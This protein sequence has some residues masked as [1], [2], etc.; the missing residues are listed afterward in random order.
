MPS[1]YLIDETGVVHGPDGRLDPWAWRWHPASRPHGA[2]AVSP[3]TVLAAL[4]AAGTMRRLPVGVIGPRE[5]TPAQEASA[6]IVGAGIAGM[7]L[8][9]VCGGRSGVMTAAAEGA[10]GAGGLTVGILPGS[11]WRE[12]NDHIAMP[13]A[14][15]IGEARNMVIAKACA[16]LVAVGGS[17]G[18]LSEIAYGLHF[19][20]P[21]I[22]LAD[23]PEVAGLER[24]RDAEDALDRL[25]GHLLASATS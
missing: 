19:A 15:G 2:R 17:Y 6:R 11:D 20:K 9:M 4:N 12:A 22:G 25:A 16:V 13:I 14:T 23:A 5:A 7:G 24:A 3:R 18:T 21:V 8:V 1:E 10:R